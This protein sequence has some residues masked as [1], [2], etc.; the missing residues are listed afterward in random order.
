MRIPR[1]GP[2]PEH[3]EQTTMA[4]APRAALWLA[5]VMLAAAGILTG[6]LAASPLIR[7]TVSPVASTAGVILVLAAWRLARHEVLVTRTAV[8][9]GL[10]P[11]PRWIAR[12]TIAAMTSRPATGW[13]SLYAQQELV[14]SFHPAS[15]GRAAVIPSA[16]PRELEEALRVVAAPETQHGSDSS[17]FRK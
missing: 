3:Y 16:A 10:A 17:T 11:F 4:A 9:A 8:R 5:G 1:H 13:R 2:I 14:I 15:G 6:A 12:D 7:L